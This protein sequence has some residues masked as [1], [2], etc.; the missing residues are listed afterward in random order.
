MALKRWVRSALKTAV[1]QVPPVKRLVESRNTL[2]QENESLRRQRVAPVVP[3]SGRWITSLDEWLARLAAEPDSVLS[4]A[5]TLLTAG[6]NREAEVVLAA[7]TLST[8]G[9]LSRHMQWVRRLR[10]AKRHG[11]ALAV[12]NAA[13]VGD[14]DNPAIRRE[15]GYLFFE[16]GQL[17]AAISEL[18]AAAAG[19]PDSVEETLLGVAARRALGR[20]CPATH[21]EIIAAYFKPETATFKAERFDPAAIRW[22][23]ERYGCALIRGLFP[24]DPLMQFHAVIDRNA[25]NIGELYDAMGVPRGFNVGWPLYFAG[26]SPRSAVR[27]CFRDSYPQLFDPARM[28]GVDSTPLPR[29]VFRRLLETGL[30]KVIRDHLRIPRLYTSAAICHIRKFVPEGMAWFGEFH[31]DNRLYSS[32]AEILTL[33]FPFNYLHGTMPTLEFLPV[34][35]RSHFPCV[36]ACGIDN[37]LF[38][39]RVLWRPQ[40]QLGDGMLLSGYAPH[41]TVAEPQMKDSRT[42]VDFWFFASDVPAPIYE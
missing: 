41:R 15:R 10:Y 14:G 25:D 29:F 20:S 37:A 23:L 13:L 33:W 7:A 4:I 39:S 42:S 26:T 30:N 1:L 36:S 2:L 8:S 22:S 28:G 31:Q 40:Y 6:R 18:D 27:A 34:R 35:S 5:D 3:E 16:S 21:E 17:D 38:D 12:C 19:F 24:I 11:A 9:H 32:D